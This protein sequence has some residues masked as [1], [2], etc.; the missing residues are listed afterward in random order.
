M[1]R[2]GGRGVL[3]LVQN[4]LGKRSALPAYCDYLTHNRFRGDAVAYSSSAE[5]RP[6]YSD[7]GFASPG[8]DFV[9]NELFK[10]LRNMM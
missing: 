10:R 2:Q 7:L 1:L 5:V 4:E 3:R 8:W 9:H 6:L